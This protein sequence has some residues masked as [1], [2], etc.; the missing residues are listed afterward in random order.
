[1]AENWSLYVGFSELLQDEFKAFR[2][3]LVPQEEEYR[4]FRRMVITMVLTTDIASPE[5]TQVGKSKWKEAFG[6]PFE[7]VERKMRETARMQRRGSAISAL[8]GVSSRITEDNNDGGAEGHHNGRD[9]DDDDS[10]SITPEN[11]I[12]GGDSHES[13]SHDNNVMMNNSGPGRLYNKDLYNNPPGDRQKFERRMSATS[14]SSRFRQRLGIL[15]TVDLSGE[16]LE[17]YQRRGSMATAASMASTVGGAYSVGGAVNHASIPTTAGYVVSSGMLDDEP[18][19]LKVSVV[20]DTLLTAADVAHNLQGWELMV[21]VAKH[22]G[23]VTCPASIRHLF[24]S[25]HNSRP[26]FNSDQMVQPI[27]PR[28]ASRVRSTAGD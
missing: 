15:R 9:K 3:V 19:E 21:R 25:N 23:S 4:R 1:M 18:D 11:S 20:M 22:K 16:T 2:N 12:N 14:T 8:S 5:R 26:S 13:D 27:V 24:G 28:A 6:D 7:T 17:T 10:Y